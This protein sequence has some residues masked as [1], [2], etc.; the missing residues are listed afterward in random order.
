MTDCH[1][2]IV[3]K[4]NDALRHFRVMHKNQPI[5]HT[6]LRPD[7]VLARGEEALVL[8]VCCP[9]RIVAMPYAKPERSANTSQ[10]VNTCSG[11]F[12]GSPW[13]QW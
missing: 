3:K 10:S 9:S 1:N 2:K 6:T 7:L 5:G 12:N 8:G 11:G 13:M 4:V